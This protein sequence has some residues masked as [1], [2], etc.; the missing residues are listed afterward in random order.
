M[1]WAIAQ[2]FFSSSHNTTNC[3]VRGKTGRQRTGAHHDTAQQATIQPLLGQDMARRPA[4]QLGTGATRR[5]VRAIGSRVAIQRFVSWLRG[6]LWV[7]I[8]WHCAA[9]QRNSSPQY[10]AGRLA[11]RQHT[12]GCDDTV[13]AAR[14]ATRPAMPSTRPRHDLPQATIWPGTGPR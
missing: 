1:E 3:I 10:G 6:R 7:A 4:I 5:T 8:R 9:I 12:L 13:C 11:T 2:F 14:P